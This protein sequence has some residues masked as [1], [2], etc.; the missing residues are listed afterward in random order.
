MGDERENPES[1]LMIWNIFIS[2]EK[3]LQKWFLGFLDGTPH[4]L[5]PAFLQVW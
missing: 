4:Q 1:S 2:L 5:L 3:P